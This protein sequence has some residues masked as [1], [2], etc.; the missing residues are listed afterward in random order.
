MS[1]NRIL[2]LGMLVGEPTQLLLVQRIAI[3][4][5]PLYDVLATRGTT[6]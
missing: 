3:L 6:S 1:I 4:D 2:T 5:D